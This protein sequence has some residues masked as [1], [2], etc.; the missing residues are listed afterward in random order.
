M[1]PQR[2]YLV[3]FLSRAATVFSAVMLTFSVVV[4]SSNVATAAP[5]AG[6][7]Q[8]LSGPDAPS[9]GIPITSGGS[10]TKFYLRAPAGAACSGDSASGGYR[11][12]SYMVPVGVDPA[13]LTFDSSGPMPTGVGTALRQP[14]FAGG[15]GYIDANTGVA[16]TAGGAGALVDNP[17]FDFAVFGSQGPTVVP[18]GV[19]NVGIACTK[20]VASATQLDRYWNVQLTFLADANDAPSGIKWTTPGSTVSTTTTTTT[21]AGATTTTVAGATTTTV[22]SGST[23]SSTSTTLVGATTTVGSATTLVAS[24]SGGGGY[25]GTTIANTG[26][27]PMPIVVWAILLLVFGRM[28]LLL[29][30]PLRVLPPKS[31]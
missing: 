30:R 26:S 10:A 13:G 17:L 20:G 16:T 29:S 8:V 3:R 27:S 12:Q 4:L 23:T 1:N 15:S 7:V 14:L 28:A 2:R 22:R 21:I 25:Y 18:N 11:V 24:G 19:Y 31:R 6:S 5:V 9:V